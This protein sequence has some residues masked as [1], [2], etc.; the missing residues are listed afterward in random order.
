MFHLIVSYYTPFQVCQKSGEISLLKQQLR[1]SQAEVTQKLSEL[2]QL[3]TQLRET[4]TELRN[5]EGQIDAL[6]LVL[7]GTKRRRCPSQTAPEDGKG[8]EES[9]S[10]GATGNFMHLSLT[11]V[12]IDSL[13]MSGHALM[14][15]RN[16]SDFSHGEAPQ[17]QIRVEQFVDTVLNQKHVLKHNKIFKPALACI[18]QAIKHGKLEKKK[19]K[20]SEIVICHRCLFN[21]QQARLGTL[22]FLS[23]QQEHVWVILSYD[24]YIL[25]PKVRLF[26]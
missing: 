22:G 12:Y 1:D 14:L 20:R 15:Q 16:T 13:A 18:C 2:F 19:S 26:D 9:P 10:V 24:V 5:R 4:R 23:T 6:K 11:C 21:M 3:K 17:A 25:G 7:Q 8:A